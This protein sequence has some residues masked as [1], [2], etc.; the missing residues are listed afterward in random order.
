[1]SREFQPAKT[2][3]LNLLASVLGRTQVLDHSQTTA[4]QIV[5]ATE[6]VVAILEDNTKPPVPHTEPTLIAEAVKFSHK[7]RRMVTSSKAQQILPQAQ[8][9]HIERLLTTFERAS[10]DLAK[11]KH[12]LLV[13]PQAIEEMFQFYGIW[14]SGVSELGADLARWAEKNHPPVPEALKL[15]VTQEET[16]RLIEVMKLGVLGLDVPL[17]ATAYLTNQPENYHLFWAM[18]AEGSDYVTPAD[19]GLDTQLSFDLPHN[20]AHLVHLSLLREKGVFGYLDDMATRA[21]FEAVAVYSELEI[22]RKL[23]A[24]PDISQQLLVAFN[25]DREISAEDLQMWMIIDRSFE[26]RLRASRL[27]ADLLAIEGASLLEIV[28][29]VATTVEIPL[30]TAE[31]EVLKYLPWTGLGAIYTLGYRKLEQSGITGVQDVLQS[32]PPTTWG[33]FNQKQELVTSD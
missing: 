24:V 11:G 2:Y 16:Q 6:E 23:E 14:Q 27:L 26:F 25:D 5:A 30:K 21:F 19:Y 33:Q 9:Q 32:S 31:S 28:D 7:L 15:L 10:L 13:S 8:R 1:M 20:V 22:V 4:Q 12:Q 29:V 3:D 18:T 17:V